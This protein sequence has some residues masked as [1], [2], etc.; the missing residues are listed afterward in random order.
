MCTEI[1]TDSIFMLHLYLVFLSV[2]MTRAGLRVEQS[3]WQMFLNKAF[4]KN[5]FLISLKP[6]M[7]FKSAPLAPT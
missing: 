7:S 5:L 6:K 4:S 3:L 1:F 2:M